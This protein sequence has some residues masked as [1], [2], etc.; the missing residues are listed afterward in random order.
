MSRRLLKV[1][2]CSLVSLALA[3][4]ASA[5]PLLLGTFE[6]VISDLTVQHTVDI[7]GAPPSTAV[8]THFLNVPVTGQFL[9]DADV[10]TQT[11]LDPSHLPFPFHALEVI[12]PASGGGLDPGVTTTEFVR[13]AIMLGA[14]LNVPLEFNRDMLASMP[15]GSNVLVPFQ[16][17]QR[18]AYF[19]GS[20]M[21]AVPP[22]NTEFGDVFD[23][24][25]R[26]FLEYVTPTVSNPALGEVVGFIDSNALSLQI[27]SN[28]GPG[29][30]LGFFGPGAP[31]SFSWLDPNPGYCSPNCDGFATVSGFFN[32]GVERSTYLG[33]NTFQFEST[34]YSGPLIFSRVDLQP[35]AVPEPATLSLLGLGL[36]GGAVRR[37][38]RAREAV[39]RP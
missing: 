22:F 4:S 25:I 34:T 7:S 6:A 27:E 10:W 17:T 26:N 11:S 29:G 19:E 20:E 9:F 38:R 21:L 33:N 3:G 30:P 37:R 16:S 15:A 24:I 18:L 1:L 13:A 31:L 14:G 2:G 32:H 12:D 5:S 36:I 39:A 28:S 23:L 35:A 8:I